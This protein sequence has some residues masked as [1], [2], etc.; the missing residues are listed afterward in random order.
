MQRKE[1]NQWC[2]Y[3]T[4]VLQSIGS[5]SE[6]DGFYKSCNKI[7]A[8]ARQTLRKRSQLASTI[9]R[10]SFMTKYHTLMEDKQLHSAY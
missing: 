4:L 9:H 2:G 8:T 10:E 7:T 5:D 1:R 3:I 6:S